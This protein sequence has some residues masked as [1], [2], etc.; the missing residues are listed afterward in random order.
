M[1][2][3][4]LHDNGASDTKSQCVRLGLTEMDFYTLKYPYR[5]MLEPLARWLVPRIHPDVISYLAVPV[6]AAT[7]ALFYFASSHAYFL[8]IAIVL[9]LLRM[10]LNT[11]DGV[12]AIK[13]GSL[14]LRGEIVNALPDRYSDV[15]VVAGVALSPLCREWLG[16]AALCSMFLVSYSGM[17]GKAVGVSW[18]HHGPLGKVER[19]ILLQIFALLQYVILVR[20]AQTPILGIDW[21][22]LEWCMILF[23]VLGQLTV[24]R[25]LRGQIDEIDRLEGERYDAR[26]NVERAIVVYDT[27]KENT[28]HIAESIAAGLSCQCAWIRDLARL[29]HRRLVV[30][31][32]PTIRAGPTPALSRFMLDQSERPD[33]LAVA[34]T[35]GVPLWGHL[36]S[37]FVMRA[38]ERTW[39]MTATRRFACPG[40]HRKYKTYRGR[41][42]A[43]DLRKAYRFGLKLSQLLAASE[44]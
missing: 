39:A 36:S 16:F 1:R 17:L 7:G 27:M 4:I 35:F 43:G 10:T 26:R 21:T 18:Q 38:V 42:N 25:R 23:I 3:A 2:T 24:V 14:S 6:A 29:A 44:K 33:L 5:R 19:L 41:P 8:I 20:N 22:P 9:T 12:V 32:S 13:R 34:V 37:R 15:F 11:L 30:V 31:C 40:Y 28:R